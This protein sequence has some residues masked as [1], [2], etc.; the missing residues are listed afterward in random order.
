MAKMMGYQVIL[1]AHNSDMIGSKWLHYIGRKMFGGMKHCTRLACSEK[2][3]EFMFGK[4]KRR[5]AEIINNAID[6]KKFRY[7]ASAD[8]DVRTEMCLRGCVVY[9]FV[10]RFDRQKN[11]LFLVEV[12]REI[13]ALDNRAKFLLVG[14]GELYDEIV[15]KIHQY[16]L[17]DRVCMTGQRDD[18]GKLYSAMDVLLLPSIYEGLPIVLIEA[19]AAGVI[20]VV[21]EEAV[22]IE[23]RIRE[24]FIR[25]VS[26]NLSAKEWALIAVDS[27]KQSTNREEWNDEVLNS[28]YNIDK[29]AARLESIFFEVAEKAKK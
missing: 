14:D 22:P 4:G 1:H 6:V 29:E 8:L 5:K 27:Y 28:R 26:I 19:Q 7:S 18:V 21:S 11:P 16:G 23:T 12:F 15:T 20:S 9:G 13:A 3:A 17:D 2:A 10:G 25:F 24:D